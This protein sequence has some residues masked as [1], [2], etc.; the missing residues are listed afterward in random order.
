M[1][2][3]HV[4]KNVLSVTWKTD[5]V[6]LWHVNASVRIQ[7]CAQ[8]WLSS[9]ICVNPSLHPT[10]YR[11]YFDWPPSLASTVPSS[12]VDF[13]VDIF[14]FLLIG[15][16][17]RN[18]K[19]NNKTKAELLLFQMMQMF[20]S[21]GRTCIIIKLI[22]RKSF[23]PCVMYTFTTRI[24]TI[25]TPLKSKTSASIHVRCSLTFALLLHL[26]DIVWGAASHLN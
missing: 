18:Y 25:T 15:K 22:K 5:V 19:R 16:L 14:R 12:D 17:K 21:N 10:N 6:K 1:K 11:T 4:S 26:F 7:W 8:I 2:G 23:S 9:Q 24:E 20:Q 3:L 13:F